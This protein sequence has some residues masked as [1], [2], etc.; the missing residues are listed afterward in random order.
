MIQ[1]EE[2]AEEEQ[3]RRRS[4]RLLLYS[5]ISS[6]LP[7]WR[8]CW[9]W[10]WKQKFRMQCH[11]W[12]WIYFRLCR[13]SQLLWSCEGLYSSSTHKIHF[14]V[15]WVKE[16]SVWLCSRGISCQWPCLAFV[17]ASFL[18]FFLSYPS[19]ELHS[20]GFTSLDLVIRYYET[21]AKLILCTFICKNVIQCF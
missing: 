20:W 17:L 11:S 3:K 21:T 7:L 16:I 10:Y 5:F 13:R 14:F 12:F 6:C 19:L 1:E 9:R 15:L 8:A 4:S 18:H 2:E